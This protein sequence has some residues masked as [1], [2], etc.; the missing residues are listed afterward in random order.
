MNDKRKATILGFELSE[1]VT[2]FEKFYT[3]DSVQK[4]Q[5]KVPDNTRLYN[6]NTHNVYKL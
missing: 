6:M 2:H 5:T 1:K 4:Q 3:K